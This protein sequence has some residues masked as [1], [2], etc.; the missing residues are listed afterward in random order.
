MVVVVVVLVMV[1]VVVVGGIDVLRNLK[2]IEDV[3]VAEPLHRG[4]FPG[5]HRATFSQHFI[6][7][8][9][10]ELQRHLQPV[11][12]LRSQLHPAGGP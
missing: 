11:H 12:L 4:D 9:I 7:V 2:E 5:E 10:D 6:M 3:G 8:L 1:V